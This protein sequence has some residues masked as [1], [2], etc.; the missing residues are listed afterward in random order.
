MNP[1]IDEIELARFQAALLEL[2]AQPISP[3]EIARRLRE[4]AVFAPFREYS[5]SF[6]PRFLEVA[7]SLVKK[8]G[9][10]DLPADSVGDSAASAPREAGTF[11][12]Y[13]TSRDSE[14]PEK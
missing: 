6:E 14:F 1:T 5:A 10:E 9:R 13:T 8:W 3:A 7:A 4:E 2:L 12:G 11:P